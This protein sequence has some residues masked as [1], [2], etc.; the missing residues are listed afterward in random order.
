[1]FEGEGAVDAGAEEGVDGSVGGVRDGEVG[2]GEG[3]LG[4]RGGREG[5]LVFF[6]LCFEGGREIEKGN[7]GR[8]MPEGSTPTSKKKWLLNRTESLAIW[9]SIFLSPNQ[10]LLLLLE[11]KTKNARG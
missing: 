8:P 11:R 6:C 2:R 1:M 5:E 3:G 9:A 7:N 4:G 10:Y